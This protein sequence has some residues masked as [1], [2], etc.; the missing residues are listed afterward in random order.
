MWY[1]KLKRIYFADIV[2]LKE[3]EKGQGEKKYKGK[4][5]KRRRKIEKT[6][7]ALLKVDAGTK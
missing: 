5:E 7:Y 6:N 1:G 2:H 3:E 4:R